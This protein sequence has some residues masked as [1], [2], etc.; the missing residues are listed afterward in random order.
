M[1]QTYIYV[2][3]AY[4]EIKA[5]DRGRYF[6]SYLQIRLEASK[7]AGTFTE[8]MFQEATGLH[9]R[10]AKN[11][12]KALIEKKY[13]SLKSKNNYQLVSQNKIFTRD[14]NDLFVKF[15][16]DELK[17]YSWKNIRSF[18]AFLIEMI[19][20]RTKYYQ[21]KRHIE[22]YKEINPRDKAPETIENPRYLQPEWDLFVSLSYGNMLLD[23]PETT[24]SGYR[25]AQSVSQYYEGRTFVIY[26]SKTYHT[27]PKM[28]HN[29][30]VFKG[31]CKKWKG[32]EY[33]FP[34]S[35]RYSSLSLK[36]HPFKVANALCISRKNLDATQT[37]H[38][39]NSIPF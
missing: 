37:L 6:L 33:F 11:H 23:I 21:K 15:S 10:T 34:I 18:R 3:L 16:Q 1:D 9:P 17:S 13:I 20:S 39:D 2:E 35:K 29:L 31:F 22:K 5:S 8:E 30:S 19:Y 38:F 25:R 7:R 32:K 36:K 28:M 27:H 4:K 12:I 14:K 26:D 24:L